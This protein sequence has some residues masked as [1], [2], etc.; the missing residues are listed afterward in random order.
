MLARQPWQWQGKK[1]AVA[2]FHWPY[3]NG[4]NGSHVNNW[5][6]MLGQ[7]H[8]EAD[9]TLPINSQWA[10]WRRKKTILLHNFMHSFL[11][12]WEGWF[13]DKYNVWE[14]LGP[15]PWF[16]ACD[17]YFCYYMK[18]PHGSMWFVSS[19]WL[20]HCG[21]FFSIAS[22]GIGGKISPDGSGFWRRAF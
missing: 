2:S 21:W 3:L 7:E 15:P 5:G 17:C 16:V 12:F 20:V 9:K 22:L 18:C 19:Q 4:N 13:Q 11:F 8:R 6:K 14:N 1:E 10:D